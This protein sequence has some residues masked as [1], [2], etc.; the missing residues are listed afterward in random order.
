[1]GTIWLDIPLTL[2]RLDGLICTKYNANVIPDYSPMVFHLGLTAEKT[3]SQPHTY[4]STE[5]LSQSN[6][7]RRQ[8]NNQ[9]QEEKQ[10]IAAN[11]REEL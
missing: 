10:K 1:M 9:Q 5:H 7:G 2:R 4:R 6:K 11:T 3:I 8:R